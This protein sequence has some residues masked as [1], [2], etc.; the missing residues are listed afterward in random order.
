[1]REVL[2]IILLLVLIL[3]IISSFIALILYFGICIF[4][5]LFESK[6]AIATCPRCNT[7]VIEEYFVIKPRIW[8]CP[9]CGIKIKYKKVN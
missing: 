3:S 1:M 5:K 7:T 6:D 4:E 8:T 9:F 2:E